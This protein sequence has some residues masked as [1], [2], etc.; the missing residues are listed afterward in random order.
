MLNEQYFI[1]RTALNS[2]S[3]YEVLFLLTTAETIYYLEMA[4]RN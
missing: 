1:A 3:S 4:L 2:E